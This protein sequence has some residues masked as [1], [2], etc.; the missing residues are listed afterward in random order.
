M[1]KL[2]LDQEGKFSSKKYLKLFHFHQ[3]EGELI[4]RVKLLNL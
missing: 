3:S 4:E 1:K 2:K